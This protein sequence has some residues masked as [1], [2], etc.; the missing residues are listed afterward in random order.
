MRFRALANIL[1]C[2]FFFFPAQIIQGKDLCFD[3]VERLIGEE[4]YIQA[5]E[6]LEYSLKQG[7]PQAQY[8]AGAIFLTKNFKHYN[9]AKGI[10]Y[11]EQATMQNFPPA[12]DELAGL[13][14]AGEGVEKDEKKALS[15]YIQ[16]AYSGYGPS[17]FNCGI[18]YKIGQATEKDMEKAYLFL[19]LASLNKRDLGE[20]V[21]SAAGYRDE[22]A[23]GLKPA[24][25]QRVLRRVNELTLP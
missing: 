18:M 13:Y 24:Q 25:R 4:R 10:G 9:T 8:L 1:I 3:D 2:L 14:L 17:Q 20:V 19:S 5:F 22:V 23:R 21:E 12:L 16:A 6:H 15:Y 11:L 7:N